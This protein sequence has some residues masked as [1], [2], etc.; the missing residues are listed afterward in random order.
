LPIVLDIGALLLCLFVALIL[1]AL[2]NAFPSLNGALN[3]W[4]NHTVKP[5]WSSL[6][7]VISWPVHEIEQA[8]TWISTNL[9][10]AWQAWQNVMPQVQ[11]YML[12]Q[13]YSPIAALVTSDRGLEQTDIHNLQ[14][15]INAEDARA[16]TYA[17]QAL[18]SAE[19][20]AQQIVTSARGLEQT[21]VHNLQ[22]N[23]VEAHDTLWTDLTGRISAV[24]ASISAAVSAGLNTA[25]GLINEGISDV[26]KSIDGLRSKEA[27]DISGVAANVAANA[28]DIAAVSAIATAISEAVDDITKNCLNDMCEGLSNTSKSINQAGGLLA[29]GGIFAMLAYAVADPNNA[30]SE[31]INIVTP[32]LGSADAAIKSLFEL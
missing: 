5:L 20:Q 3:T 14:A 4:V 24:S 31:F 17:K 30:A 11:A 18:A 6:Q 16:D 12:E 23:I 25:R 1:M 26:D 28:A 29:D 13:I 19:A 21:D 10:K 32:V 8:F 27:S 15:N 9:Q 2:S 7:N 22:A